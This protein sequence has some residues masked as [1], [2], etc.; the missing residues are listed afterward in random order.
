MYCMRHIQNPVYYRIFRHIQTY[1]WH[2]DISNHIASYLEPCITLAYPE[3]CHIQNPGIFRTRDIFQALPRH[4]LPY[5]Q[6]CVTLTYREPCHVYNFAT[7]RI[8]CLFRHIQAYS[9]MVLIIMFLSSLKA[10]I[11]FNKI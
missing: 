4:V 11:F 1:S 6:R 2:L 8:S 7:F 10:Y 3:L 9:T 5:S